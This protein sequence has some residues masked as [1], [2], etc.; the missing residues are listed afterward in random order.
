[1]SG[2]F[3]RALRQ[4]KRRF[5]AQ[6]WL[7]RGSRHI[8]SQAEILAAV[9]GAARP[10]S[11]IV[12]RELEGYRLADR[13]V[14]PSCHVADSFARDHEAASKL[15]VNPYG[16]SLD[17]FPCRERARRSDRPRRLVFAG[18]WS[19]RKGCDVLE[20]AVRRCDNVVLYHVGGIGDQ[21]FPHGDDRFVHT[22]AVP[23]AELVKLYHASDVFVHASREEGLSVVQAQALA[24]GL[25]LV[26]TDRTGGAD[27]AHTP[28]LRGRIA[29][30]T[31][32]DVLAMADAIARTLRALAE[33]GLPALTEH[34]RQTLSWRHYGMRYDV[35][36]RRAF[37]QAERSPRVVEREPSATT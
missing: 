3:V 19:R 22:D 15:F 16:T 25:P 1:M 27:L 29:V 13:I 4:S 34:D 26:C 20:A 31:S 21:S 24:S 11:D 6:V 12:A 36:L 17:M 30:V 8:L 2:V 10:Y 33:N 18:T 7:E 14:V 23:Q 35:E 28:A 5:G 9:P 32:D 37:S